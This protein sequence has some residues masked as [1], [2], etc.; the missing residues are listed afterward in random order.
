MAW[1]AFKGHAVGALQGQ[2]VFA[3]RDIP[4]GTFVQEYLGEL[5]S[6]W[7]W[8]EKQDLL[9]KANPNQTLPDFYNIC[10]ERPPFVNGGA[11]VVFVEVSLHQQDLFALAV[12]VS[13]CHAVCCAPS[14][15]SVAQRLC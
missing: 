13:C 2:G 10:L 8:F 9:R 7:R 1:D 3:T 6:P 12:I 5:Y 4:P 11:D 15:V 14:G